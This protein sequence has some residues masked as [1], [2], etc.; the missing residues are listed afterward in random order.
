MNDQDYELIKDAIDATLKIDLDFYKPG[1][2]QRRLAAFVDRNGGGTVTDFCDLLNS[3]KPLQEKLRDF[4]TINVTEFFRDGS[5][6]GTLKTKV[7]PEIV[8]HTRAPKI[9][10]AGSSRGNEAYSVAIFL[11][12]I[13]PAVR[14]TLVGTDIDDRSIAISKAGGPYPENEVKNA[15]PAVLRKY[16]EKRDDGWYVQKEIVNRVRFS[17]LNL[18][19]DRF[20]SGYDLIMCRNVVIYFSDE[21]KQQLNEK[22]IA[23]LKP[24]GVLFV[25]GT[26]TIL[27]PMAL[28]LERFAPSF[29]RKSEAAARPRAA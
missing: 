25:G 4:L 27:N 29:Y 17:R 9:W 10:S 16:F 22:F 5:Q 11:D 18:L 23:A 8:A 1:Q 13:N 2:M 7:L 24:G 3:D 21:A 15:D 20:D 19:S 14:P 26:E 12:Q 28:G 6:F